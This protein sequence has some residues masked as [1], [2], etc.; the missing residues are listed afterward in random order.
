VSV[1]QD[2]EA[3]AKADAVRARLAAGEDFAKVAAEVSAAAS[4]ANGGLIGPINISELSESLQETLTRMKPG[5][6][7]QPMRVAKG[8]HILKLET[9]K[10]TVTPPFEQVRDL[11]AD[12]V[13]E[14]RQQ[15]EMRKFLARMRGQALIEWKNEE[16]KK[17]YERQ[18]AAT[19]PPSSGD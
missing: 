17:A 16:L 3:K 11:V 12:R 15:T 2:D 14:S 7:S 5:E 6:I 8:F 10:A 19:T 1:A 9:M 18:I 4:K 13:H